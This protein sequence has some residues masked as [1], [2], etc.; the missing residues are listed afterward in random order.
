MWWFREREKDVPPFSFSLFFA[1]VER[2]GGEKRAFFQ[3]S[4]SREARGR[5][6]LLSLSIDFL[7]LFL[8]LSPLSLQHTMPPAADASCSAAALLSLAESSPSRAAEELRGRIRALSSSSSTSASTTVL[9]SLCSQ[10]LRL[11]C[12]RLKAAG[13]A[14]SAVDGPPLSAATVSGWGELG[15]A[16]AD[17]LEFASTGTTTTTLT[18]TT[19]PSSPSPRY[20]AVETARYSLARALS[21]TGMRLEAAEQAARLLEGARRRWSSS[22]AGAVACGRLEGGVG[23][24]VGLSASP[25]SASAPAVL[26]APSREATRDQATLV[27]GAALTLAAGC[28]DNVELAAAAAC[29]IEPWLQVLSQG[30]GGRGEGSG[31]DDGAAAAAAAR[32]RETLRRSL[33]RAATSLAS[34]NPSLAALVAGRGVLLASVVGK[35]PSAAHATAAARDAAA[36]LPPSLAASHSLTVRLHFSLHVPLLPRHTLAQSRCTAAAAAATARARLSAASV[37]GGA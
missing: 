16:A 7:F 6:Q 11:A 17:G 9:L 33:L 14:A 15:A 2:R 18:T 25:A 35:A 30:G 32:H 13:A 21:A 5:A 27:V 24:G 36:A 12:E 3:N 34:S 37:P 8:F 19:P 10:L 22:D 28:A 1:G 20:H 26:P 23:G 4:L 29:E 31:D